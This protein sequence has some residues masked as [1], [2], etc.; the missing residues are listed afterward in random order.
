VAINNRQSRDISN[1]EYKTQ[2]IDKH[3]TK[4]NLS[5]S[6]ISGSGH[7]FGSLW[8]THIGNCMS[9]PFGIVYPPT[10]TSS[11]TSLLNLKV[12]IHILYSSRQNIWI[13]GSILC[14]KWPRICSVC[15]NHNPVSS[16]FITF[17]RVCNVSNTTGATSGVGT[18]YPSTANEVTP[19][20][21]CSIVSF[22]CSVLWVIVCPFWYFFFLSLYCL[23]FTLVSSTTSYSC[24]YLVSFI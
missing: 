3:N 17:H 19:V 14:G 16:S 24:Y 22:L 21:C 18:A 11:S 12:K 20:S 13:E 7:K 8:I 4:T 6:N 23:S 1:I 9:T 15:R 2:I 10:F 5:G